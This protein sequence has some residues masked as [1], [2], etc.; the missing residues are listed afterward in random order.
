MFKNGKDAR[1]FRGRSKDT[2]AKLT[3]DICSQ[4]HP[5]R[6]GSNMP[7]VYPDAELYA[8]IQCGNWQKEG[9][10]E[11]YKEV[12]ALIENF[13]I[14]IPIIVAAM[15]AS[16]AYQFQGQLPADLF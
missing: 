1:Q 5:V 4:L 10:L 16:I 9:E 3:V 15:G 12:R 6:I 13:Q 7:T 8:E 2:G 14:P 11:K